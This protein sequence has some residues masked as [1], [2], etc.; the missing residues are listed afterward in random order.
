MMTLDDRREG[1]SKIIEKIMTSYIKAPYV[2]LKIEY[3][4]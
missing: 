1:E 2:V 3:K 4:N